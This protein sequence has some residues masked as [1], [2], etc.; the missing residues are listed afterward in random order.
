M[1]CSDW[2]DMAK[3]S[4]LI[5]LGLPIGLFGLLLILAAIT[6]WRDGV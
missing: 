5:C 1:T 4:L 2:P 6:D 3:L